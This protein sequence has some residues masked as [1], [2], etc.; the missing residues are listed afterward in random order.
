MVGIET[1][2]FGIVLSGTVLFM[3]WVALLAIKK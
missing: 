1:L 3:A 2:A